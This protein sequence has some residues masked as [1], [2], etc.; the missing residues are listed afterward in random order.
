M[1][2]TTIEKDPTNLATNACSVLQTRDWPG[3][4]V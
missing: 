1:P 2:V 3:A 4:G